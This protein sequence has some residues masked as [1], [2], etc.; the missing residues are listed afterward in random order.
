MIGRPILHGTDWLK[1]KFKNGLTEYVQL[2]SGVQMRYEAATRGMRQ[3]QGSY[4]TCKVDTGK[5]HGT[6]QL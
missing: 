1:F 4:K 5:L 2:S 3:V 6:R